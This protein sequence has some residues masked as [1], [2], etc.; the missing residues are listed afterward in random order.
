[1]KGL[2]KL[3]LV[4]AIAAVSTG[5]QA[6][7]TAMDDALMGEMTGQAGISI[8]LTAKVEIGEVAYQDEGF[9]AI[10]GITLGGEN[11]EDATPGAANTMLDNL[12]IDID[13]AGPTSLAGLEATY[14]LLGEI[15]TK[16]LV[17]ATADP[18]VQGGLLAA[19][20]PGYTA[21]APV[22]QGMMVALLNATGKTVK[23]AELANSAEATLSSELT[24]GDGIQDGDLVI[25]LSGTN[26]V[27]NDGASVTIEGVDFG[28]NIDE[29]SLEKS[30]YNPGE[31][32]AGDV[33]TNTVLLANV[34]L[35]GVIGPIDI[36][37]D[38]S[39]STLG[40]NAYFKITDGS[41]DVPFLN[42]SVGGLVIDGSRSMGSVAADST[43]GG[44]AHAAVTV[45][46]KDL[47]GADAKG[48]FV[49]VLDFQADM[50]ITDIGIGGNSI[51]SLY[52]TDLSVTAT[53]DVYGH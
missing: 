1:M 16:L 4:S 17:E 49:N 19:G 51:G 11:V 38:E 45:G 6:E 2:K 47:A 43:T 3:V 18:V 39:N 14:G 48:L 41:M 13:V 32:L 40:V 30:T 28:L 21:G 10:R 26:T 23:A 22:T 7:L 31:K 27:I 36:I 50:D 12:T 46:T 9:I 34:Q 44:F 5:A 33:T 35:D 8:D 52:I 29:V 53:M 15:N 20:Y 37:I 24:G 25:H 42:V